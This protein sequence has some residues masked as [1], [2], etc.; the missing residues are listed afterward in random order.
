MPKEQRNIVLGLV[1]VCGQIVPLMIVVRQWQEGKLGVSVSILLMQLLLGLFMIEITMLKRL[2]LKLMKYG[3]LLIIKR[4]SKGEDWAKSLGW[5]I[6]R[7]YR[8]DI[9][10]DILED[11]AEM[12]EIGCTEGRIKFHVVYQWLVA[13]ITPVP[14]VVTTSIVNAVKQVISPPK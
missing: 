8:N 9:I 4:K 7:K 10:G 14:T 2:E 3:V 1:L 6:P 5:F 12:R 11:C 13:V